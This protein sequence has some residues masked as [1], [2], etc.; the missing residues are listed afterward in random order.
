MVSINQSNCKYCHDARVIKYGTYK[1]VQRYFCKNCNR[2]YVYTET[3]PKMQIP[4]EIVSDS[5][6]MFYEGMS[7]NEI[8][9]NLIRQANK[10][11]SKS[12][13]YNWIK[14]FTELALKE[15][16]DYKPKVG[17]IWTAN[18]T[19]IKISGSN[20]FLWD[21]MDCLTYFLLASHIAL[22]RTTWNASTLMETAIK[23]AGKSPSII[24]ANSLASYIKGS[25]CLSSDCKEHTD[26]YNVQSGIHSSEPFSSSLENRDRILRRS[27][28]IG[29]AKQYLNGFFIYYNFFRSHIYLNCRTPAQ[30]AK[31]NISFYS[32]K[33]VVEKSNLMTP[34]GKDYVSKLAT[35]L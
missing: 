31:T 22:T 3:L 28:G 27:K 18:E 32:W 33:D 17:N 29:M 30:K 12:S 15:E 6:N 8:R 7:L 20:V 24:Y 1:G 25:E 19:V 35:I 26:S 11:V 2:K 21:I 10:Y 14:H 34:I 13:I 9:L 23:C 5:I 4:I 16:F